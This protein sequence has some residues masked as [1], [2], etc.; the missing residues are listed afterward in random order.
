MDNRNRNTAL[1]FIVVGLYLLLG[2][3]LGFFTVT[4]IFIIGL[5]IYKL[6]TGGHR[7]GYLLIGVGLLFLALSHLSI[8]LAVILISFGFFLIRNSRNHHD[9]DHEQRHKILE[10]IRWDKD[11]WVLRNMSVWSIIGEM[12]LDFSLAII[13]ERE[14][15]L[16]FQGII[17][18]ID[19]IV[20][21][22]IGVKIQ[23]TILIG[24]TRIGLEEQH[25]FITKMDW[26]SQHFDTAA[27]RVI[28]RLSYLIGDVNVKVL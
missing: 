14:T 4:A 3:L 25:G 28:I 11:P 26:E 15:I 1:I 23:S 21:D 17:G 5:G 18:D 12:N 2:N 16:D 19:I 9:A 22:D 13:E 7:T 20:P 27:Q 24:Q 10:S 6:R 8:I